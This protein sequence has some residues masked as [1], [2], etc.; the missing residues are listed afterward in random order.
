MTIDT[1]CSGSLVSL[2]VACRY[3]D[4][5]LA[6]GM[7][8]AGANLWMNPEHNEET[9]MMRM[10]QSASGKC[11]TFDAKADGYVKAEAINVV[12][13]KR[14]D[15]AIAAGD[16]IRAIIRG[17][18][19]N[20][21]GRTPGIASPSSEAQADAIRAAYANAGI[22]DF[23]QTAY[24][25]C[26]GQFILACLLYHKTRR[27]QAREQASRW[28]LYPTL[29]HILG[30][31]KISSTLPLD[32]RKFQRLTLTQHGTATLVGDGVELIGAASVF[33]AARGEGQELVVG[34]LK[35]NIGHSEA[36]AGISG[37]IKA[38]LAVER[39]IIPGNPTF[40][41]P[42]PKIDFKGLR[43]RATRTSIKWPKN[44]KR[45]ASVNSFGFGGANAHAVLEAP[46]HSAHAVSY[47]QK[48]GH[49][50]LDFDDDEETE[51]AT[52]KILVFS[53]NDQQSLKA[54]IKSLSGH[55]INPAVS[56]DIGDLAYT[57][58]E[59][60]SRHYFRG[61]AITKTGS[62]LPDSVIFGKKHSSVVKIGFVF[63]G[64][65]AQWSQMGLALF[66]T[67]STAR[68]VIQHLDDVLQALPSPPIWT[69]SEEL[70]E[71]R[72]SEALRLPEFSQ[73]L[74]TALQLALI[75]VLREWNIFPERYAVETSIC[76]P[77]Q[78]KTSTNAVQCGW[79]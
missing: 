6:D 24:L 54:N 23:D 18:S 19:T 34:S 69:L 43:V 62:I 74:V 11:H 79:T 22:K 38:I 75:A 12:F 2:D 65:G 66:N 10:T 56:V 72:T 44:T 3:L 21:A 31:F 40:L 58:S 55:L 33:S 61:F 29:S 59:R 63:T 67:F 25:E 1:A 27:I 9:G 37:L 52:P 46:E 49:D 8:V 45:R 26:V 20:S 14:L 77:K 41:E 60:R 70:T 53:A 28:Q 47:V 76:G 4:S 64:Q 50:F 68:K 35:A 57:L 5:N 36:A 30:S 7:I 39:G 16:P 78:C 51:L 13:L 32:N 71:A 42:N 15:D 48:S 73:P 17:T